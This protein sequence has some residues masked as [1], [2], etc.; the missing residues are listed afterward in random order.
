VASE[1]A[2]LWRA[3]GEAA[4]PPGYLDLERSSVGF[5][6]RERTRWHGRLQ[7]NGLYLEM[8]SWSRKAVIDAARSLR[9]VPRDTRKIDR[10]ILGICT[11]RERLEGVCR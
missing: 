10:T 5:A 2:S 3:E 8:E 9:V 7:K 1:A 4:P 6:D 11:R